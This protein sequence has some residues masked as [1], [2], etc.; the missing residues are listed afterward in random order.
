MRRAERR[1]CGWLFDEQGLD[2]DNFANPDELGRLVLRADWP[3]LRAA[4]PVVLPYRSIGDLFAGRDA[5]L[6]R[7]RTSLASGADATAIAGH[8][9]HGLGGV[10][11]T[12]LAVEYA[13]RYAAEY[14]AVLFVVAETPALLSQNLAAL[15]GPD[16]LDL[17]EQAVTEEPVQVAAVVRWLVE[18]PG[19]LVVF[20]NIDTAEAA[21]AVDEL[22]P[23]LR[24]GQ[25]LKTGRLADWGAGVEQFDL[26]VL[27]TSAAARFLLDRTEGRRRPGGG[28]AADADELA[29]ELGGLALAL[30]QAGAYVVQRRRSLAHY[31][32]DWRA[33]ERSVR[34]WNDE[35]VT[36]YR[37]S[38]AVT[39]QTTIEQLSAGERALLRILAWL[40]PE[41][42]PVSLFESDGAQAVWAA[43]TESLAAGEAGD[44]SIIDA[45]AGL[46]AYSMVRWEAGGATVEAHRVVQ[47]IMRHRIGDDGASWV[48]TSMALLDGSLDGDPMDVRSWDAWDPLRPH[49]AA[50]VGHADAAGVP[51]PT[52]RLMSGL[53]LL[54][55]AKALH[56]DAEP[57]MRRALTIDETAYGPDHPNVA[58]DLNNL[59]GLL[60]A[61]NRLT[62]AE[63]LMRRVVEIF[64]AFT[65]RT[66]HEHPHLQAA[67]GNYTGLLR[68]MGRDAAQIEA[69][70]SA[71]TTDLYPP[72]DP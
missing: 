11:K 54:L 40:A 17:P 30:E 20:D 5:A 51:D 31:L 36:K 32:D 27:D 38:V 29:G 2:R 33:Q 35:R 3:D 9:V 61:T 56:A 59:A 44:G 71:L 65:R 70:L 19:W 46:A 8:V 68:A 6:D 22:L 4:V 25:V 18:H 42:I 64:L 53:G 55:Y 60:Q 26:D 62:D 67:F 69:A 58:T 48:A 43:A 45:L 50:A 16:G 28:D 24:G 23:R 49:V 41:P 34:E 10:G 21:A 57:L 15:S 12:R 37:H 7:L 52:S 72:P 63:P 39:W 14:N 13:W 1:R 47:D 66:G